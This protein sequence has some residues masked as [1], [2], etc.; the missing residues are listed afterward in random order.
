[1]F[2]W[3]PRAA[4]P[5]CLSSWSQRREHACTLQPP[6]G[7]KLC[8][9]I[10]FFTFPGELLEGGIEE[11]SEIF[12]VALAFL[13]QFN[14]SSETFKSGCGLYEEGHFL[15]TLANSSPAA[16]ARGQR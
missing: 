3:Q 14:T 6:Q 2:S 16:R 13:L 11:G 12:V 10:D 8:L 15:L 1:M 5:A 4:G 9:Q 7:K